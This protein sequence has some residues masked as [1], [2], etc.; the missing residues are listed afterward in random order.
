MIDFLGKLEILKIH[1]IILIALSVYFYKSVDKEIKYAYKDSI[2][3]TLSIELFET[4][5]LKIHKRRKN[6]L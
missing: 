2:V 3:Y 6:I 1:T 5:K 4:K